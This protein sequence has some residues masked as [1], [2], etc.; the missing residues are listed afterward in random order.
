MLTDHVVHVRRSVSKHC[1][2]FARA[3]EKGVVEGALRTCKDEETALRRIH[4]LIPPIT[5]EEIA[6]YR[7]EIEQE[8]E[9]IST[10]SQET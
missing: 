9:A 8:K 6:E 10:V 2:I 7:R 5:D 3:Y 4:R 1:V